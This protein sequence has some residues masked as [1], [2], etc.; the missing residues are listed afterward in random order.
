MDMQEAHKAYNAKDYK[1]ALKYAKK[2]TYL[3]HEKAKQIIKSLQYEW[4]IVF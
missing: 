2:A 3:G 1:K 4:E